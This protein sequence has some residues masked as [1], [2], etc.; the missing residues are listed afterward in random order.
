MLNTTPWKIRVAEG[1]V[2]NY[3]K[4]N[5]FG[6]NTAIAMDA[7]ADVWDLGLTGGTLTWLAPTAARI[8]TIASDSVNDVASGTGATTVIISYLSDWDTPETEE[9]VS[10]DLNAGIVMS[11]AAVMINRMEI[12]PQASSTTINAGLITATA[13]D[14]ATVTAAI[15]IGVGQTGQGIFGISS[16]QRFYMTRAYGHINKSGGAV[17]AADISLLMNTAPDV[18]TVS[19]TTK[20][21][22]GAITTGSSSITPTWEV[23]KVFKGP[24]IFKMRATSSVNSLDITAGFNGYIHRV[25]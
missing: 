14:D 25:S 24:A 3:T 19:F 9:T 17:G 1:N 15:N 21:P 12:I 18:Q 8:H 2:P 6:R 11:N 7:T 13:A 22:F 4:I 23:F 10:G 5:K 20:H 16:K